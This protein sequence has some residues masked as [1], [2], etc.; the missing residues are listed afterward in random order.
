MHKSKGLLSEEVF[1][2]QLAAWEPVMCAGDL[3]DLILRAWGGGFGFRPEFVAE[4]NAWMD[5]LEC[6]E[7]VEADSVTDNT[8]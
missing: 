2:S 6:P 8:E 4:I 7:Q 3:R 1:A 5:S